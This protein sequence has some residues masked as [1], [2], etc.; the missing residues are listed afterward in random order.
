MDAHIQTGDKE[1]IEVLVRDSLGAPLLSKTDIL[2]Q[3]RRTSDNFFFDWSDD[4]FKTEPSVV[5]RTIA[6]TEVDMFVSPGEYK[7][8]TGTH[9]NGFDTSAITNAVA[10]GD[11]YQAT[12]L[13]SPGT[14][15]GNLP[16]IGQIRV[17]GFADLIDASIASI[18]AIAAAAVWE[19][20]QGD[21]QTVATFGDL[22]QR[23]ASLQKENYFIDDTT[24][25]SQGLLVSG[26]M[27]LFR[28]KADTDSATKGG[29]GEG[30]F[31]IYK[32]TTVPLG[33]QP[34]LADT[35]KSTKE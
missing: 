28:T 2:V 8:T 18:P 5:T 17:G 12:V 22:M 16:L 31:A 10:I 4:T 25:N 32:V 24:Y 3:I 14:D 19:E 15:A 13:Q 29:T 34:A 23:I 33:S 20:L 9:T 26:R 7:L 30:E 1:P 35:V 27:R 21:H 6:L 11:V